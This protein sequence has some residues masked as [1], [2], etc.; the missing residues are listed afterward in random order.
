MR[1]MFR[2]DPGHNAIHIHSHYYFRVDA[3]W[4]CTAYNF[5][6]GSFRSNSLLGNKINIHDWI[7]CFMEA[8][9]WNVN[10]FLEIFTFIVDRVGFGRFIA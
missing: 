8:S 2:R 3:P 10:V 9:P 1:F 7:Y 5:N 6:Q 4:E